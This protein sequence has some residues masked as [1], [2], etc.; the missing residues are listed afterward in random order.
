MVSE[1]VLAEEL[2]QPTLVSEAVEGLKV[3]IA[4]VSHPR[5]TR[6]WMRMPTVGADAGHPELC[7]RCVEA[8]QG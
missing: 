1:L 6:C 7:H 4:P 8:I 2:D 5:C 3:G